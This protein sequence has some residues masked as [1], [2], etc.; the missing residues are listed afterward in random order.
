[1]APGTAWPNGKWP[2]VRTTLEMLQ[3]KIQEFSPKVQLAIIDYFIG[4]LFDIRARVQDNS[5]PHDQKPR[6][7]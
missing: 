1:M 5:Y 7:S 6:T 4:Q 2:K 3:W